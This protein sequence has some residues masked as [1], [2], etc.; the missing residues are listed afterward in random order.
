MKKQSSSTEREQKQVKES[1]FSKNYATDQNTVDRFWEAVKGPI[2]QAR[3]NRREKENI[4]LEDLK[5]WACNLTDEH[6]YRGRSNF[7]APELHHQTENSVSKYLAGMF[8][9]SNYLGVVPTKSTTKEQAENIRAAVYDQLQNRVHVK[10]LFELHARQRALMGTSPLRCSFV[11]RS[12]KI[13]TRDSATGKAVPSIIPRY[14]GVHWKVVDIFRWYIVPELAE[15]SNC[16]LIFEDDFTP[17]HELESALFDGKPMYANLDQIKDIDPSYDEHQ[18]IDLERLQANAIFTTYERYPKHAFTTLVHMDFDLH[19]NGDMVPIQAMIANNNTVIRLVRNQYW[20]QHAPYVAGR[21]QRYPTNNFYGMSFPD[22]IRSLQYHMNDFGG[23]TMDSMTYSLNPIMVVDPALAGDPSS[24]V[25][26]PGAM[27]WGSPQGVDF[28]TMPDVSQSG[29]QAMSQIRG[30]ISQFSD[31]STAIAPQLQGK[32][33]SATQASIVD[34]E[35]SQDQKMNS[36]LEEIEVMVP[37][38][39]MTHALLAQFQTEDWQIQ[40]QGPDQGSWIMKNMKPENLE[41]DVDFIWHG[42]SILEKNA[43]TTQQLMGL[44]NMATQ[45]VRGIPELQ[46]KIDLPKLFERVVTEGFNLDRMDEIMID[47]RKSKTVDPEVE[48]IALLEEQE[49]AVHEGD[50]DKTHMAVHDEALKKAKGVRQKLAVLRHQE[51]H[52]V[53]AQAKARLVQAT[54]QADALRA[55]MAQG[56]PGGTGPGGPPPGAPM[57][58]RGNQAQMPQ[59]TSIGDIAQGMR[60]VQPDGT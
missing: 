38:C 41:G 35:V 51:R 29:F 59:S 4:W 12:V 32:A 26:Q 44:F 45:A 2:A 58:P 43:V 47:Q 5:L 22:R 23:Q 54:A 19:G 37:M 10:T 56:A 48:N 15:I 14:R 33:R 13:W 52:Q 17:K 57:P 1:A 55:S 28:K 9:N 8:P 60:G 36:E 31:N 30:M 39:H 42:A 3:S 27:W 46:S 11:D 6:M 24:F 53:S 20:F 40:I 50:D 25:L 49:V 21:Y 7:F 18:W 16:Y 34:N